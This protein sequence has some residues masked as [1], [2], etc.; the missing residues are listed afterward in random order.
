MEPSLSLMISEE[1]DENTTLLKINQSEPDSTLD[2]IFKID[3]DN[4]NNNNNNNNN[5]K[6]YYVKNNL[7]LISNTIAS[8]VNSNSKSSTLSIMNDIA[9]TVN[10]MV[11]EINKT[12]NSDNENLQA[13]VDMIS[14]LCVSYSTISEALTKANI[15]E[16]PQLKEPIYEENS[17][18]HKLMA[19]QA[20]KNII[21]ML[22]TAKKETSDNKILPYDGKKDSSKNPSFIKLEN[23]E[24]SLE[25]NEVY[26]SNEIVNL[27]FAGALD[28][29]FNEISKNNFILKP[30]AKFVIKRT[31]DKA[32]KAMIKK[33]KS[34]SPLERTPEDHA[35][36][37]VL[38]QNGS[39]K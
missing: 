28:Y 27:D 33:I 30:I 36:V 6:K 18:S 39:E 2:N 8:N 17:K 23:P 31:A 15:Q 20:N 32:T 29:C 26:N 1:S 22:K 21:K 10:S 4:I 12:S 24:Y 13:K 35:V 14:Q 3:E 11:N 25:P 37:N 19:T 34:T 5:N 38:S 9:R 7:S 16:R